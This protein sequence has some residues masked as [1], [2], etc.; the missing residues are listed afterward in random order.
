MGVPWQPDEVL[1]CGRFQA[2]HA[3]WPFWRS[4]LNDW[5]RYSTNADCQFHDVDK[6]TDPEV[7]RHSAEQSVLS[8]LALKW[9]IER[10]RCPDQAGWPVAHN[11][12]YKPLDYYPQLF[13]QDGNR[14]DTS[15]LRGS[16]YRNV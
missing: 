12:T 15:D 9:Q 3:G 8:V 7:I 13:I 11:G 2:F 10:H 5:Q 16:R 4:F 14:G 6:A 1:A